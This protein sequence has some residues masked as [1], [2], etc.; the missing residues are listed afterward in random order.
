MYNKGRFF[1]EMFFPNISTDTVPPKLRDELVL[2]ALD[3][4]YDDLIRTHTCI[5]ASPLGKTLKFPS[6]LI[7]PGKDAAALFS[8]E[9]GR[10]PYGT[11]ESFLNSRRLAKLEDLGMVSDYLPWQEIAERAESI[12]RL[13]AAN[14]EAASKRI[15]ALLAFMEKTMKYI[16]ENPPTDAI[17]RRILEAKFLP[18]LKKP[19]GFP[20]PWKGD[21]FG[22]KVLLAPKDV[23]L[24]EQKYL[25]C[26]TEPLVGVFIPRTVKALL[27][28]NERRVTLGHVIAQLE[29]AMSTTVE[30]SEVT[31][32]NEISSLCNTAYSCLQG[33]LGPNAETIKQQL[34]DKKFIL[35]G[36]EFLCASQVAFQL[37]IDC[38]PYLHKLPEPLAV[39]F[40]EL[41]KVAGVREHFE[42]KD[43]ISSLQQM[44]RLFS[45]PN[46]TNKVFK[47]Q[48]EAL[49]YNVVGIPFGQNEKLT[50]RLKR[51]LTCYPCEK[52]ILKELLQNADD[53]QATEICFIKDP[54]HHPDKRVF[55]DSWQPLQGPALCVYNNKPF[56]NADIEGI[57]NLG[58]GSKGDDPNKTG[59]YGVG[60][61]AVYHLTDA[62]SFISKGKEIGDVLCV[63]DPHCKY[64]PG[65][66]PQEPG[67]MFKVGTTLQKNFPDVF[68]CYLGDHFPRDNATMFRFPLRT[69][70]M[71]RESKISSS[72]VSLERID[73]MMEELK[74]EL[75]EVLLFVNNIGKLANERGQILPTEI[76]VA[77]VSYVLHI[78][79][80]LGNEEKWLIVQQIGF[81]KSV[82]RSI[83]DAFKDHQLGMLPRGGVACLL[84][85]KT[86]R[87]VQRRKKAYCFLPLPLET[88]LPVHIN[89][90][91]ALKH[92]SRRDLWT[93]GGYRSDWNS[94]LLSDVVASCYL[95]LL[96]EVRTF[97]K[98][99][100]AQGANPCTENEI[101]Q[102]IEAYE[103][104]FPRHPQ[105]DQYWKTLVDS[106]YHEINRQ[107]LQILPVVRSRAS[108]STTVADVTWLP[109]TGSGRLQAV[110][111]NLATTGPFATS[112]K[113]D[114]D[115]NQ[116]KVR[117]MFE[118][119]L[120][121]SGFNLVAFSLALHESF[122]R[123]G[124]PTCSI[125]PSCVIDFYNTF[126]SQDPL[127]TIGPIP[128]GVNETSLK[129][130]LGV[131]VV[132]LYCK[133]DEHFLDKLPGLPLLLTQDNRLQLFSS[134]QPKF[135]S[136]YQDLLPGSPHIFLHEQVCRKVFS[137]TAAIKSSVLKTLDANA[138]ATNLPQTL[139]WERYGKGKFVEWFPNQ[140]ATPNQR[141]IFRVWVFLH[142]ILRDVLNDANMDEESKVLNIKTALEPL[143]NWSILPVTEAKSVQRWTTLLSFLQS[144]MPPPLQHILVPLGRAASVLDFKTADSTSMKLVDV[145]RK[146]GL[147]ELN[148]SVLST[149]SSGTSM[150]SS[151]NSVSL[152]CMMVSS[153][154]VPSSLLTS[155]DQ[156]MDLDPQSLRGRLES[157]ECITILEYFSRSV[158]SLRADDRT[159][160][161][162]L[163]FYQATNGGMIQLDDR[164]VCVLPIGIPRN[165]IDVLER[166]LSVIF[167]ESW[168]SLSELFKFLELQ[169]VSA[170]DVYCTFILA[171]FSIL[172][173]EARHC[174]L[175]YI[176][177]SIVEN[178]STKD[179][180]KQRILQCLSNTPLVPSA[181]GALKTASCFYDPEIDVFHIMLPESM[182]PSKPLNSPEW[183]MFLRNIGLVHKVTKDD[184]KRFATEVAHEAALAPNENTCKKSKVL[185][186]HLMHRHNVVAEGLLQCIC[187]IRFVAGEPVREALRALC[188][189]FGGVVGRQIPFVAFKGAVP[190][191]QAEIVWTKARFLPWWAVPRSRRQE[192]NR[193]PRVP[194]DVYCNAF[195][196][197]L[198][199]VEK[200]SVDLV[201]SHCQNICLQLSRN[202]EGTNALPY[203]QCRTT[204]LITSR[205]SS[206]SLPKPATTVGVNVNAR[207]FVKHIYRFDE[208]S[209]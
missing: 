6:Q 200:P 73:T 52:E 64:A 142:E 146:L 105:T 32:Y 57:R 116:T 43:Y 4:N 175:E 84:E 160:L 7:H 79:D 171:K 92:E 26:C 140:K 94:A 16:D 93:D 197:Q 128:C 166:A 58:E 117:K 106:V 95:T 187:D 194:I 134:R 69:E 199:I 204:F 121:E 88:N 68:P 110:F 127:C 184:F 126:S 47:L 159:T 13:N 180:D 157:Q 125:S 53:A 25:L 40:P 48:Q 136:R 34:Q 59:Q 150:Y 147:P 109:P 67:R 207:L 172:S 46:L 131:I 75:F 193:P 189:P 37:K 120:L 20:L 176:R 170:V 100:I 169:C 133:G 44:K 129:D 153:L 168:S 209:T 22:S 99:P 191:D 41:M 98:L 29:V 122:Q 158:R 178:P 30:L 205:E 104:F 196:T 60:F 1:R 188:L 76:P 42:E 203:D 50:N 139:P 49:R 102:K 179:G 173:K 183:L 12:H 198:Q 114:T 62:P 182:F 137:D 63:F 174:H 90:H 5:P 201:V 45:E 14:C 51:L 38:S 91:F 108:K 123:A 36:R 181:D 112:P 107:K 164:K 202:S 149:A 39:A 23:F 161:Q 89:G 78:T 54:R 186:S 156:K 97:L 96:V 9:D 56:T 143:S 190:A 167:L 152:A 74:N 17:Q 66:S 141:W 148:S 70:Q 77:K 71:A 83:V 130:A 81:D 82:N 8:P 113:K 35:A 15:R 118:A 87:Y 154:K 80:T 101:L 27:K 192:L 10:F 135:L 2:H 165:E 206:D 21:D 195:V 72:S 115:E 145:L 85:K 111:N 177:K 208:F 151:L 144:R 31:A 185:V 61:N 19:N 138:F 119:I 18:V 55:E 132:L 65:A 162:R 163:P 103:S 24:E 28:L 11:K 3:T 124:V 33:A 86:Q 155:L